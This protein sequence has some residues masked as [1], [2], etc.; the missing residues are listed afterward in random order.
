MKRRTVV[1]VVLALAVFVGCG[2]DDSP[3]T[4][5]AVSPVEGRAYVGDFYTAR[6][7][8]GARSLPWYRTLDESLPSVTYLRANG[9]RVTMASHVVVGRITR[10][11]KGNGF[12]VEGDDAPGG[13]PTIFDDTRAKWWR[14]HATVEV[15]RS[16]ASD[17]PGAELRIG[18]PSAGPQDFARMKAGLESL[19]RVVLFMRRSASPAPEDPGPYYVIADSGLLV[20]TVDGD[21]TLALPLMTPERA[22][23]LLAGTP[24]LSDLEERAR[25]ARVIPMVGSEPHERRADAPTT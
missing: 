23:E 2:R 6:G 22:R 3:V 12:R 21:G 17:S 1:L 5:S 18:L 19:G 15:E 4:T 20:A 9:E 24:R 14:V 11:E 8:A 7:E 16:I 13:I 10:V 25:V